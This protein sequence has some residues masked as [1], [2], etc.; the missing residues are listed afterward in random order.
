MDGARC[1]VDLH[2][3]QSLPGRSGSAGPEV[4]LPERVPLRCRELLVLRHVQRDGVGD[5]RGLQTVLLRALHRA[6]RLDVY[7]HL[8]PRTPGRA[9]HSNALGRHGQRRRQRLRALHGGHRAGAALEVPVVLLRPGALRPGGL[10]AA[11][12]VPPDGDRPQR[13]GADRA[14]W[15][16]VPAHDHRV[17]VLSARVAPG[18]RLRRHRRQRRGDLLLHRR[19]LG[20]GGLQLHDRQHYRLQRRGAWRLPEG[21]RVGYCPPTLTGLSK[22]TIL[23]LGFQGG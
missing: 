11:P 18:R 13:P 1:G 4:L 14:L 2:G 22:S 20:Q 7:H 19:R 10:C 3:H 23:D 21:V 5:H 16:C 12:R 6:W 8:L 9:G 15:A 17:V